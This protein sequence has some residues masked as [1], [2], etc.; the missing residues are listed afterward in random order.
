M[1]I[2]SQKPQCLAVTGLVIDTAGAI[3]N[4]NQEPSAKEANQ[5]QDIRPRYNP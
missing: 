1:Q 2:P 4:H 3:L 5:N